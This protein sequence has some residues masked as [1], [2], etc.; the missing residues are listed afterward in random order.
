LSDALGDWMYYA[1][2]RFGAPLVHRWGYYIGVS[3]AR[4]EKARRYFFANHF[5]MVAASKLIHAG[6]VVGIVAA[7]TI[8]LPF[9]KWAL[10]CLAISI[11]Q[12]G[13]LF[14]LGI[15]FGHAYDKIGQYLNYYAAGTAVL[16]LLGATYFLLRW[17]KNR[18]EPN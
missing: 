3:P 9:T 18:P 4:I 8:K 16:V 10:Q 13:I 15:F 17:L 14:V 7:G 1:L 12:T 2:G 5:K 11:F 6:G